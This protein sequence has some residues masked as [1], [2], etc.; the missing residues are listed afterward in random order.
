MKT[1]SHFLKLDYLSWLSFASFST[2]S[3]IIGLCLPEISKDLNLD[4]F[5]GSLTESLRNFSL[6]FGLVIVVATVVSLGKKLLIFSGQ[7]ILAIGLIWASFSP[8]ASLLWISFLLV[9]LGG[10]FI[11][12]ILNPLVVDLHPQN[13]NRYMSITNAFYPAGVVVSAIAFGELL[14]LGVS[15]RIIFRIAAGF[16]IFV[17]ILFQSSVFPASQDKEHIRPQALLHILSH[18]VFWFFAIGLYLAAGIESA[19]MF[20]SRSF[21]NSFLSPNVRLATFSVAIFAAAMTLGRLLVPK[22]SEKFSL[23]TVLF[24]SGFMGIMV[25]LLIPLAKG[26]ISFYIFVALAGFFLAVFWPAI[27]SH[28]VE[29]IRVNVTALLSLLIV[30]GVSG[31]GSFPLIIGYLSQIY[32]LKIGLMI[33]PFSFLL[34]LVMMFLIYREQRKR[35]T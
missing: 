4:H 28:S 1:V 5:F 12:G 2:T 16:S 32:S 11:E 27:M 25:C 10:G 31:Y 17:G 19:L 34:L 8:S 20:W 23:Y 14:S 6:L 30:F 24:I 3:V 7:Y 26:Y 9:G 22:F 29:F 35:L 21:I 18:R 33:L 15:W 13:T